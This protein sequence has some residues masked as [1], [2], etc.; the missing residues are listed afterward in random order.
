MIARTRAAAGVRLVVAALAFGG[1]GLF[2]AAPAVPEGSP[3]EC[4]G[5]PLATCD[6][7]INDAGREALAQGQT[8]VQIRIRCISPAG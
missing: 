7:V 8:L 3:V 1:C 5:V 6:Q 2:P 4:I